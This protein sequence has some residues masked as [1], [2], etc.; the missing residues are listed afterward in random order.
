MRYA[1]IDNG[2]V[3]N[4]IEAEPGFRLAGVALVPSD[5]AGPGWAY[6]GAD[7]APPVIP[8]AEPPGEV[9]MAW[10]RAALA[11][12]DKLGAVDAAVA[13][14]GAVKQALWDYATWVSR[15]DPDVVAIAGALR[16]DLE[17]LFT[18]A[19]EIRKSRGM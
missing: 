15:T 17:A 9:H 6:D 3:V 10:L 8:P 1:V 2:L 7:F 18:R 4:V 13:S 14:Q 19:D 11:E 16:I 12:A 5:V